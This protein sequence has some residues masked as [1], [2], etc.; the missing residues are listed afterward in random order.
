M[1]NFKCINKEC[2]KC[3]TLLAINKVALRLDPIDKVLKPLK[4]ILC[5]ECNSPL[6]FQQNEF[7]PENNHVSV[8]R[9]KSMSPEEKK[10]A[11]KARSKADYERNHKKDAERKRAQFMTE[12]KQSF[13]NPN[14]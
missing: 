14:Q 13:E 12:V 2:P 11:I 7:I 3:D 6:Q 4:T 1:P 10:L 8:G 9:F 5:S